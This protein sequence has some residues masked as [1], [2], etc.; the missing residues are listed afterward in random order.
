MLYTFDVCLN[1]PLVPLMGT[2]DSV[3]W[4]SLCRWRPPTSPL[5]CRHR[6][7]IL[8]KLTWKKKVLE[9]GDA[10]E[11]RRL[12]TA[13]QSLS[14]RYGGAVGVSDSKVLEWPSFCQMQL[15]SSY[16][17]QVYLLH[18]NLIQ[19]QLRVKKRTLVKC[20]ET[21]RDNCSASIRHILE[22]LTVHLRLSPRGTQFLLSFLLMSVKRITYQNS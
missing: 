11:G 4:D 18:L 13:L 14:F 15:L 10:S 20:R 19:E 21:H 1:V 7:D 22:G 2:D 16:C 8:S 17:I 3:C 12:E 5:W 6:G 9:G